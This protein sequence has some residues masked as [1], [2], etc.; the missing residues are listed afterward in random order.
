MAALLVYDI[1]KEETFESCKDWLEQ[2]RKHGE[3]NCEVMLIGNKNDLESN[4]AVKYE[5]ASYFASE[6]NLMFMEASATTGKSVKEAFDVILNK[7]IDN[8]KEHEKVIS[9]NPSILKSEYASQ[10]KRSVNSRLST[11]T[12]RET[13]KEKGCKC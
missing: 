12:S 9:D 1:T 8:I 4:R 6:N 2:L 10:Y 11:K 7:V 3:T 5:Q 13:P